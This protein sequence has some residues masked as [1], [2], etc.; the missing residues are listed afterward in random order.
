MDDKRLKLKAWKE[1][2]KYIR[3][4]DAIDGITKCCTCPKEGHWKAFHAGHFLPGRRNS[5][6][7]EESGV[8]AQCKNCNCFGHGKPTVYKK[9]MLERYGQDE[10]DRLIILKNAVRKFSSSDLEEIFQKYKKINDVLLE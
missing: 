5:I 3:M 8:H 1:F 9:F 2:S 6:L 10:I 7:F 4:R